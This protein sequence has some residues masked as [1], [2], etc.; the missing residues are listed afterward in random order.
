MWLSCILA[1]TLSGTTNA[2]SQYL[3]ASPPSF[4]K[5]PTVNISLAWANLSVSIIF[6][7]LPDVVIARRISPSDDNPE[8]T[9][10]NISSGP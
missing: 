1:V 5:K 6:L 7:E 10:L 2:R 4:P 3:S 9:L 8:K